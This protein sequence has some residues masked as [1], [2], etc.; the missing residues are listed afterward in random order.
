MSMGGFCARKALEVTENVENVIAIELLAACQGVWLLGEKP[1][2]PLQK[3]YDLVRENVTPYTRDR[4]MSPDIKHV[5]KLVKE[6]KIW[7]VVLPYI[8]KYQE[9]EKEHGEK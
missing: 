1:T 7:E 3:V 2:E 9:Y 8:E 5:H 6:N 4:F